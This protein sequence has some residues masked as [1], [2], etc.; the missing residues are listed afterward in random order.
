MP[1]QPCSIFDKKIAQTLFLGASVANFNTSLGWGDQSSQLTVNLI[2]DK[3]S[4]FCN[5]VGAPLF[6]QFPSSRSVS[7]NHYHD[8]V[9]DDCYM[10]P[11]GSPFDSGQHDYTDRQL[12][13]KVFYQFY[14]NPPVTPLTGK[15][16]AVLSQYWT[17]PDPGFMGSETAINLDGTT[18]P[19]YD[20]SAGSLNAGYDIINCPVYFR[21]GD[22]SFGG[23]VQSW[24]VSQSNS[25]ETITVNIEDLKSL[26]S[27]CY[28]I[29]GKFSGAVFSKAKTAGD[30]FY[31][32]PHNWAG[33]DVDYLGRLYN[34]NIPNVFNVYGFL[35]SFG[36][37]SFG[38]ANLNQNGISVNKVVDALSVLTG[39]VDT[40]S[41]IFNPAQAGFA[42]KSAFSPFGRI[43]AKTPQTYSTY[44]NI[45]SGFGKFGIVPPTA[46]LAD[47]VDRSEF[48]LDL[49][50]IPRLPD[51]FRIAEPV[52]SITDLITRISDEAGFD[53]LIDYNPITYNSKI[54]N[55]IKVKV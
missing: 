17:L 45:T 48:V 44:Q 11:D 42:Q 46:S 32:K 40:A 3:A 15:T 33:D 25:G 20:P 37:G 34:G 55:V 10:L 53:F 2:E 29:L 52:M 38:A 43:L 4:G 49:S 7:P 26:L 9:G 13:G 47:G 21:V 1:T 22:F 18:L 51:D 23:L 16:N 8:C 6:S 19:N 39:N 35:E 30:N 28:I 50:E 24:S 31:G 12:L 36:I 5:D 27:E 14:D 41:S 54:T